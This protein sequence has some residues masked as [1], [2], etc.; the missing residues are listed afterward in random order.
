MMAC[1][2]ENWTPGNVSG[3]NLSAILPNIRSGTQSA[4]QSLVSCR[5]L[6]VVPPGWARP[7]R[8]FGNFSKLVLVFLSM[9]FAGFTA[10]G[11][12][13]TVV[14][15][16]S[17]PLQSSQLFSVAHG[18]APDDGSV[19]TLNPPVFTWVYNGDSPWMMATD[20][21][22]RTFIFQLS[23]NAN[24]S[25][26]YWNIATSNNV[27]NTLP[28][29]TNSDGST[30]LGTN[31]WRIIY[32]NNNANTVLSTGVVHNFTLATTATSW[33]RSMLADSN[34]LYSVLSPHP[35][36]FFWATNRD[37]VSAY[38]RGGPYWYTLTNT[39]FTAVT[40]SWWNNEN[41]FTNLNPAVA[42]NDIYYVYFAALMY[43]LTT[44]SYIASQNPGTMLDIYARYWMNQYDDQIDAYTA[45]Y[46]VA[47]MFPIA[48][49]WLWNL[50]TPAQRN[51]VVYAISKTAQ[52]YVAGQWWFTG[53]PL[54]TNRNYYYSNSVVGYTAAPKTGNSHERFDNGAG[55]TMCLSLWNESSNLQAYFPYYINMSVA[56]KDFARGDEGR[57]YN[58]SSFS[59]AS[60]WGAYLAATPLLSAA[61]LERCP[62]YDQFIEL[63]SYSEPVGYRGL[64]EPWGDLGYA[65]G[66]PNL[67]AMYYDDQLM[68]DLALFRNNG[69][70]MAQSHHQHPV[71]SLYH[72]AEF[73]AFQGYYYPNTPADVNWPSNAY[74][75]TL[76]GYA[77]CG[78][79]QPADPGAFTNG[80][81][82]M[83]QARPGPRM[84]HGNPTD[85]SIQM[86]AYGA[87]IT[88]GGVGG[89]RKHPMYSSAMIFVDGIGVDG[90]AVWNPVASWYSRFI[91]FTNTPD[92]TYLASDTTASYNRTNMV[93]AQFGP[94]DFPFY[95]YT[96]NTRPY[97]TSMIRHILFPHQK[98]LVL[99]DTMT[100]SQAAQFQWLWH[101]QEPTGTVNANACSFTY[102]C[103]NLYN[104]GTVTVYV[105]PFVDPS[106]MTLTNLPGT[107]NA[108]FNP[109]T[110][111]HYNDNNYPA[112]ANPGYNGNIWVYNTTPTTNW[113]FGWVVYPVK[114]NGTA[115]TIT[116]INDY[117]VRVQDGD[118]DDTITINPTNGPSMFTL[119][120]TGPNLGARPL[121]PPM[122]LRTNA[123]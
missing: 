21:K 107:N 56:N 16:A 83:T 10:S 48:A 39:A 119:N 18:D 38:V 6:Y 33:D 72:Y 87:Q 3:R 85:G 116:R 4:P 51:D 89:Y 60:D 2:P 31:Y 78:S 66:F 26:L 114:W 1:Y 22:P 118:N 35:H 71:G 80:V 47:K 54:D 97:L 69:S 23:T 94:D 84:E 49:D 9:A 43:Q 115:P 101:Y 113:H 99:Y 82:F 98:Y 34:Y 65:I 29:I 32:L 19:Q 46:E 8:V 24:F 96:T 64:G 13:N 27:Y 40:Q 79:R 75:D 59:A 36:M 41:V 95:S 77:V 81:G 12:S 88:G 120:L 104:E 61:H 63:W 62:D 105:A 91:A 103:T 111:E 20:L 106:L 44:N 67:T 102:T 70:V 50:M 117:A 109:F 11:Q 55:L 28:P 93:N 42:R 14:S 86:W 25:P 52:F 92:F 100:S 112:L 76:F 73:E 74:V 57:G 123:P 108:Y 68:Q 17:L 110:G 15:E 90:S 45:N 58:R 53:T 5:T 122:N 7:G 37:A 30:Y 121:I